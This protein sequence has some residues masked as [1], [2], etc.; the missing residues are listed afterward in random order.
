MRALALPCP[1]PPGICRRAATGYPGIGAPG[2]AGRRAGAL[3]SGGADLDAINA[4][5][6]LT[7]LLRACAQGDRTALRRLYDHQ[8]ARLQGLALRITGHPATAA[9]AVHDAFIQVWENADR[10]DPERG[11]PEA[12]LTTLVRYR[13]LDILRRR[14]REVPAL[15]LHE[16]ADEDPDPLARLVGSDEVAALRLCLEAL[17]QDKRRLVLLAFM[18]GL[19]HSD[20]AQTLGIPLG[21]IKSTIRR[22]LAALKKCLDR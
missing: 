16:R 13:A 5:A 11:N 19:S 12:W 20:L 15:A 10:F 21:T 17:D 7:A 14:G 6:D 1:L 22:G 4:A 18:N 2:P 3:Q 9:D 8:A